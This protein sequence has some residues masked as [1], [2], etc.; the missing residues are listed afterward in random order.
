MYYATVKSNFK[1]ISGFAFIGIGACVLY[2]AG[3]QRG[4]TLMEEAMYKY[5]PEAW[6]RICN[7]IASRPRK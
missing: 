7:L 3:C 1:C 6:K 2:S 5:E 4:V